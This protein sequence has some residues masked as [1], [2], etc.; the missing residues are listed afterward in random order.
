[1]AQGAGLSIAQYLFGE[2]IGD[3]FYAPVWWYTRGFIK[4]LGALRNRLTSFERGLGLRLWVRTLGKPMYGQHDI[5][6]K[7]IS[8]FMR[9]V[10]LFAR[11]I[12]FVFYTLFIV[13][14][15]ILWLAIPIFVI[16]QIIAQFV[17]LSTA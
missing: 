15:A 17:G 7:I 8:F 5:A 6:G 12:A 16:W 10:V 9:L 2:L 11:F 13:A 14:L 4:F 1:M 3:F